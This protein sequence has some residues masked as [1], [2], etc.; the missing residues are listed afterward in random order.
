MTKFL[1]QYNIPNISICDNLITYFKDNPSK[2]IGVISYEGKKTIKKDVKDS[3]DLTVSLGENTLIDS[4]INEL[5]ICLN[6]YKEAYKYSDKGQ[7]PYTITEY[8][9]IQHYSPGQ[10]FHDWHCESSG[11]NRSLRHLVFMTYL[12]DVTDEGG[13]EF[14]YHNICIAPKKGLTLIWPTDWT[15]THRGIP[16]PTQEKYIITGWFS[17]NSE[18]I[19]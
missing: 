11:P 7:S 3:T 19:K 8:I 10:A 13:T 18:E 1:G 4:Y 17:Y 12:N 2:K 16:S 6:K 5:Q 15:F 9:N 14:Y